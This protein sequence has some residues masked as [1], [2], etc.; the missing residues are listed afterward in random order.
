MSRPTPLKGTRKG[1]VIVIG[2]GMG[3]LVAALELAN[4]GE[5]VLV[6]ERADAPGGKIRH[7]TVDGA[8]MDAGP[9]VF[10]MRWV[11]D[12]L[13]DSVGT[14]L[15]DHLTLQPLDVL[16]RHAW[17]ETE[18]LDLHADIERSAESIGAFAGLDAQ[19]G[20]REFC[21]RSR[22]IY[23]ALEEPF[24]KGTRPNP[25]SLVA[26]MARRDVAGL[27]RISPF[28]TLWQELG[29]YFRDPRLRQLF[30]RYATYCGS[31]PFLAPA[32]LMLV[33]HVEQDGVWRV[34]GG[35]HRVATAV[36]GLVVAQGA[37]IRYG[38]TVQQILVQGGRVT[39]VQVDGGERIEAR[40]VVFNGDAAALA[41]GRLG[42][43][44]R[45][46]AAPVAPAERS[47]S[48]LTWNLHAPA[49]GFPLLHHSVF[50]SDDSETEFNDITLR[51][52]LPRS[53][54]VYVCA[55]DR[56]AGAASPPEGPER[57]LCIVNAPAIG[58]IRP[59]FREELERC[60]A[61]TFQQLKRCGLQLTA[62]SRNAVMTTPTDFDELF[63][64]T[65]GALYGTA[66]H[67]WKASFRR[68]GARTA[69]AGLYLAGGSIHPG[70]GV[71]MVALSGRQAAASILA[72]SSRQQ[73][74]RRPSTSP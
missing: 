18:R 44:V 28:A 50:F 12:Q 22:E 9:T 32:T 73:R 5:D 65:G 19:R 17:S 41:S 42:S 62:T 47:L 67:G 45:K 66:S 52:S 43:A 61:R 70:P 33:A 11:F 55:Q 72:D 60:Q 3:G 35:M 25:V 58:D 23:Q 57:L 64:A 71:P 49:G 37:R 10:T 15:S 68:P 7:V 1:P 36:A 34:E 8:T 40:A 51:S 48:A 20:Y 53:P 2:A 24:L 39:G 69:I 14:T 31:S 46:A 74:T 63:P 56:G 16:A 30:G 54:T 59:F 4:R 26:R 27:T 21:R 29:R 38:T 13:F 6:I